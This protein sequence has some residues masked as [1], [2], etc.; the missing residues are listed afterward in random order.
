MKSMP[1]NIIQVSKTK[2]KEKIVKAATEE[3]VHHFQVLKGL[4]T[5]ISISS[6]TIL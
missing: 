2:D 1:R 4:S 5:M 3:V 6:E